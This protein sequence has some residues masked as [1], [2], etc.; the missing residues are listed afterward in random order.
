MNVRYFLVLNPSGRPRSSQVYTEQE[1]TELREQD[2][3]GFEV[4]ELT[5]PWARCNLPVTTKG[6]VSPYQLK[7]QDVTG[8]RVPRRLV[9]SIKQ[10]AVWLSYQD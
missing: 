3:S 6:R 1:I 5:Q 4:L 9:E 2:D 10:F 8:M 7:G